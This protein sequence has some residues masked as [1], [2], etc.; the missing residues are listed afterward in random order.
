[1]AR[2]DKALLFLPELQLNLPF[3]AGMMSLLRVRLTTMQQQRDII[4]M[5][6]RYRGGAEALAVG[7][8]DESV[9]EGELLSAAVRRATALAPSG[10]YS[11]TLG[12]M[13]RTL[14]SEA[15]RSL[16]EDTSPPESKPRL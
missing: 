2:A 16:L 12:T 8:V 13:K 10:P 7:L 9:A 5:G 1:M 4:L 15:I 14:H 3:T 6:T 11:Q